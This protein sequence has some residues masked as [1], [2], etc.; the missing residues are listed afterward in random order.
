MRILGV[1]NIQSSLFISSLSAIG[2]G[3]LLSVVQVKTPENFQEIEFH[4]LEEK[5]KS[6]P[7]SKG[8]RES[9]STQ[10]E[11]KQKETQTFRILGSKGPHLL[12]G[13][14]KD[15]ERI[16][17]MGPGFIGSPFSSRNHL[18]W[19]QPDFLFGDWNAG[20]RFFGGKQIRWG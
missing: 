6:S 12:D 7:A 18:S 3:V 11:Q 19:N 8:K 14:G 2:L 10:Q 15:L 9:N 4:P 1:I 16:A 20:A 5:H 17:D 13:L